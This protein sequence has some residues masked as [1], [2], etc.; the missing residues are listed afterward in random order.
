MPIDLLTG[1]IQYA[2]D[3]ASLNREV[4]R[5]S[6]RIERGLNDSTR[7]RIRIRPDADVVR[8][9]AVRLRQ[10]YQREL[11]RLRLPRL[12][13][14]QRNQTS[15]RVRIRPNFTLAET[16]ARRFRQVFQRALRGIRI[17]PDASLVRRDAVRLRQA[18]QRELRKLRLPPLSRPGG[19]GF[20]GFGGFEGLLRG[21]AFLGGAAAV[22]AVVTQLGQA[23]LYAS[24]TATQVRQI[25]RG[26]DQLAQTRGINADALL[27]DIRRSARDTLT[28]QQALSIGAR[29]LA[30]DIAPLYQ[31]LGQVLT[32]VSDVAVLY[33]RNVTE[34]QERVIAAIQKQETELLDELGITVRAEQ[35]Y[36]KY[37]ESVGLSA[38]KLN[39]QQKATAFALATIEALN[40]QADASGRLF[41]SLSADYDNSTLALGRLNK[42]W[43]D[44]VVVFGTVLEPTVTTIL[45]ATTALVEAAEA[46][47]DAAT[48]VSNIQDAPNRLAPILARDLEAYR[49]ALQA[50]GPS[51]GAGQRGRDILEDLFGEEGARGIGRQEAVRLLDA[52][53]KAREGL[54]KQIEA[55]QKVLARG[56]IGETEAGQRFLDDLNKEVSQRLEI[57]GATQ[58]RA[59]L[60]A[61]NDA[62]KKNADVL[63]ARAK[64]AENAV[65]EQKESDENRLAAEVDRLTSESQAERAQARLDKQTRD[66]INALNKLSIPT[67]E[68]PALSFEEEILPDIGALEDVNTQVSALDNA[69]QTFSHTVADSVADL[70]LGEFEFRRFIRNLLSDITR[71][72]I[73]SRGEGGLA[74]ALGGILTRA[75]G[76]GTQVANQT[77]NV[78]NIAGGGLPAQN[79]QREIITQLGQ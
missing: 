4:T 11:N 28:D 74:G 36:R 35:A 67:L 32:D 61:L 50:L 25:E 53:I 12:S 34:S 41:S 39:D 10:A 73:E 60:Q 47:L 58:L 51:R 56:I 75:L 38:T 1:T 66:R 79:Q 33:G 43:E 2:N 15:F 62:V 64:D 21:G 49:D 26:F 31:N 48:G 37:A 17:R 30:T 5:A 59:A 29:A 18:Y 68:G 77:N 72:A 6:R 22:G 40:K 20:G 54:R 71:Q 78:V 8:R 45:N 16:D 57:G 9:D 76:G 14:D 65:K 24:Q 42:A 52:E 69:L 70:A 44:F 19:G 63:A 13:S 3:E 55:Q 27:G 23:A 46:V 7:I